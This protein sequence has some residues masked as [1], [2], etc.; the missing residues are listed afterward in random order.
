ML[1][2]AGHRG[3]A[4]SITWATG[5]TPQRTAR[6]DAPKIIKYKISTSTT[7]DVLSLHGRPILDILQAGRCMGLWI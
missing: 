1:P 3:T 2:A 6:A 7:S 4:L 5:M